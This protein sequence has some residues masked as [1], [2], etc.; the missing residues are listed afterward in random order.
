MEE[1]KETILGILKFTIR[2]ALAGTLLAFT[3]YINDQLF[4]DI[5]HQLFHK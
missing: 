1:A 2:L 3:I 4:K 5:N